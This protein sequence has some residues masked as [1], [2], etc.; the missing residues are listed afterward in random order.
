MTEHEYDDGLA[1]EEFTDLDV[2]IYDDAPQF[3]ESPTADDTDQDEAD[4]AIKGLGFFAKVVAAIATWA[5]ALSWYRSHRTTQQIGFNPDGMCLK[6]C[7]MARNIPAKYLTAKQAQD[8][9]PEEHRVHAIR[10]LRRGMILFID[11]PNDSNR[12]GHIVTLAGRVKGFDPDSLHDLLV[13]TNS[14]VSGHL[15]LVRGDYFLEHWGDKFQFGAT[16]LNDVELDVP[17]RVSRLERFNNGGPVYDLNLLHKAAKA[18]RPKPGQVLLRIETAIKRLPDNPKL[19]RVRQF[20]DEWRDDRKI[21]LS[22]LDAAVREG[23]VGVVRQV[24]D[25]IKRLIATLPDE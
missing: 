22:L 24:R 4:E 17:G 9:T 11:D 10:D 16:I 18:G 20:K 8:A 12:A 15:V 14:V 3:D 5:G 2:E 21:D 1:D 7:R 25:E 19:V 6:V 23:R 13:W